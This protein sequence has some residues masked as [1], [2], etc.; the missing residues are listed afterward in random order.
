MQIVQLASYAIKDPSCPEK[1]ENVKRHWHTQT[2]RII[3][4]YN[5]KSSSFSNI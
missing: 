3:L 2:S 1:D 4:V 5:R